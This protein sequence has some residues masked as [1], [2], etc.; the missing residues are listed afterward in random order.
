M[1]RKINVYWAP[2]YNSLTDMQMSTAA[3]LNL[4]KELLLD[5]DRENPTGGFFRCP[6]TT[7]VLDHTYVW[8]TPTASRAEF[9]IT[10]DDV[11]MK[12]ND[13]YGDIF[14]WFINHKPTLKDNLLVKFTYN[15]VFFADEDV[16]VLYTAPYFSYAPHTQYGSVV[17]GKFNVGSWFRPFNI[18][19]NLWSG[20]RYI[21]I[22]ENEPLAYFTFL[23]DKDINLQQFKM[24]E[25]T[26]KI[27]KSTIQSTQWFNKRT[28][29]DRYKMFKERRLRSVIINDI[30]NN[31]V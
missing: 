18:E 28:M 6:A 27:A 25:T 15:I 12:N 21:E 7:S 1:S 30:K 20:V 9:K 8:K 24:S 5:R 4:K 31:L 13:E 19:I 14:S 3:P 23:T 22:R 26:D 16:E 11:L 17:P 29:L 2:V 10:E